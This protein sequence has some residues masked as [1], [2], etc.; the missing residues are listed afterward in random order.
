MSLKQRLGDLEKRFLPG[1]ARRRERKEASERWELWY[2]EQQRKLVAGAEIEPPWI[3][4]P[5][6]DALSGWNQ[7]FS[8]AWKL[9]VWMP[10]WRKMNEAEQANYLERW[11]PP[12][13]N[14][15]ESVTIYWVGNTDKLR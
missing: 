10:F 14:W 11:Q 5:N 13:Q 4:F 12:T 6:S 15:R 8:E 9:N 3:A 7:G 1:S 2:F